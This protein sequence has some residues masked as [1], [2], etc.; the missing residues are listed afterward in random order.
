MESHD[1]VPGRRAAVTATVTAEDT[2]ESLGSGDVPVLATPR[3]LTLAEAAAVRALGDCLKPG[4]TSVGTWVQVE[5]LAPGRI[6]DQVTADAVLLGVHGRRLEFSI[7]VTSGDDEIAQ[8][9]HRR[10]VVDREAFL[11]G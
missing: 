6:G 2:A 1:C 3:L 8:C 7:I 4:Q 9:R 10:V 5:H 11:A